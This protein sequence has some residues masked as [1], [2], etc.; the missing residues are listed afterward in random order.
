M[1]LHYVAG[2]GQVEARRDTVRVH[3]EPEQVEGVRIYPERAVI[4]HDGL[5]GADANLETAEH[6][7]HAIFVANG[8]PALE[9]RLA[10]VG[11]RGP[12]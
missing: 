6:V 8:P 7:R 2:L 5:G 9:G 3:F 11:E 10:G 12:A 1:V 4:S